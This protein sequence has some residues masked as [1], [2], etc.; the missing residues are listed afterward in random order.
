MCT[1]FSGCLASFGA[2]GVLW[3]WRSVPQ[4]A[5]RRRG[6]G[7]ESQP[8]ILSSC[9]Y[10]AG[11][12]GS[13]DISPADLNSAASHI[14]QAETTPR[15]SVSAQPLAAEPIGSN[16][17]RSA[18]S[19]HSWEQNLQDG[20]DPS[21]RGAYND[22]HERRAVVYDNQGNGLVFYRPLSP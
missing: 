1:V 3:S 2:P 19:P 5:P 12:N 18:H 14:T 10:D 15:C 7:P 17:L 13:D 16:F 4:T 9:C 20:A 6:G 21:A 22:E 11:L 8:M